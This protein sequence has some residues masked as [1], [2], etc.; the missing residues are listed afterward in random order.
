[1]TP[2]SSIIAPYGGYRKTLSFG[3]TCLI[4]H[5]TTT[6]CRRNYDYKTDPLGKTSGQM[7]GAARSARQNIVEA[8]SRAGTS[9]ETELKLLDVAKASLQ[10]LAGDFEAFL[11]DRNEIPWPD[12]QREAEQ[13]HALRLELFEPD[14]GNVRH[15]FGKYFLAMRKL[16]AP[17][18]EPEDPIVAA[19]GI[20]LTIDRA[21]AFLRRQMERNAEIFTGE[22]GFSERMSKARIEVRNA[23]KDSSQKKPRDY[24]EAPRCPKCGSP[25][26]KR[27][28]KKG[29]NAGN[30]FWSCPNWPECDGT[31]P[32]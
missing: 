21:S 23:R 5:A 1:M 20:L 8:S 2:A 14:A 18:L 24:E 32:C 22:G 29:R 16:F 4:Y 31:R 6:F 10:E 12:E 3:M 7:I 17:F 30:A 19:N 28:A 25:M 27:L 9:T 26:R 13:F 15:S 11:L